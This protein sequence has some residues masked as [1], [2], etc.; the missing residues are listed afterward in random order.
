[1]QCVAL[2][3]AAFLSLSGC[4][5]TEKDEKPEA[6]GQWVDLGLPSGLLWA[7]CNIGASSPTDYG[8][9]YAWG[10]TQPK[11]VYYWSTYMF[12]NN[13]HELT[14]YC[15]DPSFGLN[16]FTDGLTTLQPSDD[17]ATANWGGGARMPTQ[18]EWE[19]MVGNTTHQ[20]V[21]IDGVSGQCFTGPNGNSIFLPA[22]G[23]RWSSEFGSVGGCGRYWSSSLHAGKP[24]HA[25]YCYFKSDDVSSRYG[26]CRFYGYSVRA[27]RQN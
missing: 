2:A 4:D 7:S 10:E 3:S 17:A 23:F 5:R 8:N 25:W 13:F 22:A 6:S 9:Y 21:T 27:V 11:D 12:G 16:G 14:K 26:D 20:W 19:E 1:M 24:S 18:A 15:T